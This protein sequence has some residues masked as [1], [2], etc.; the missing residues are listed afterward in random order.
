MLKYDYTHTFKWFLEIYL[1]EIK[2]KH[3][4]KFSSDAKN[5]NVKRISGVP[6][7][8]KTAKSKDTLEKCVE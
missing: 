6:V 2:T 3:F 7:R 4:L 1:L 5:S 8:V